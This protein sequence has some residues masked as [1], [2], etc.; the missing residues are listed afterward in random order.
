MEERKKEYNGI[1]KTAGCLL[2]LVAIF[3]IIFLLG[4]GMYYLIMG[5]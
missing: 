4:L 1:W 5:F 3:G 2:S